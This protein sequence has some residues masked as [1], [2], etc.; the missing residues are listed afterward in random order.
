MPF[1]NSQGIQIYYE[2]EGQGPP[3]VLAHGATGNT[4]FW[5]DY[6]YVKRLRDRFTVILFDARAHGRSDK[7][8]EPRAYHYQ[9]MVND[10][11][12]VL[13]ALGIDQTHYWGYSMG[14]YIGLGLAKHREDRLL[15]LI[16]GGADPFQQPAEDDKPSELLV[17]FRSGVTGGMDEVVEGMRALAGSIT[18]EYKARLR[19]LDPTAIVAY[20]EQARRRP[21]FVNCLPQIT[22]PCLFYAGDGDDGPYTGG[23]KAA[24]LMPNASFLPMPGFN[25]VGAS[26]AAALV[27]PEVLSFLSACAVV[28]KTKEMAF[29]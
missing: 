26:A 12:R 10:V 8:H 21:A 1:V 17:L 23:H 13:D 25:H 14:G 28:A 20:L 29:V 11:I 18:P 27:L 19:T 24:A 5:R 6:G 15:S 9:N 16:I 4:T 22:L 7:P 2:V 3:I